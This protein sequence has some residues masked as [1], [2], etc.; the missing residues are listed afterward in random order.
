MYGDVKTSGQNV[1]GCIIRGRNVLGRFIP[2]PW[3][4]LPLG[5]NRGRLK[6]IAPSYTALRE[7]ND[8]SL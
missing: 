6:F 3:V 8:L 4:G 5:L 1:L 7:Y 2:L